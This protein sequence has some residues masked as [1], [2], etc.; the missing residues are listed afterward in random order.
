MSQS[1]AL[2]VQK[3]AWDTRTRILEAAVACLAEEGYAEATTSR[4]QARAGVSRGSLLHQFP[5]KDDL[6]IAAVHHLA[7]ARTADLEEQG[8]RTAGDIDAAVEALWDTLHGP[9]F[10]ATLELWIAAKNNAELAAVLSPKEHELGK[11][12]RTVLGKLFGPEL[13]ARPGFYDLL[14]LLVT[15]MR[16]VALTYTFERRDHRTDPH[17]AVWKKL[18]H[19]VLG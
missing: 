16:G 7:A 18:A 4:I 14:S 12:I 3:R 19:D 8:R 5:S 17:L 13:A 9:L 6:L 1:P 2:P 15:S 10:A 11:A